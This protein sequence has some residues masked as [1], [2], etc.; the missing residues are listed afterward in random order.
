MRHCTWRRGKWTCWRVGQASKKLP[1][2]LVLCGIISTYS[3]GCKSLVDRT[4]AAHQTNINT[5]LLESVS[6]KFHN[7]EACTYHVY[8]RKLKRHYSCA[9]IA[10]DR[11]HM[12]AERKNRP[13]VFHMYGEH[14]VKA[15]WHLKRMCSITRTCLFTCSQL[16][17]LAGP[18]VLS[19]CVHSSWAK[20]LRAMCYRKQFTLYIWR[21]DNPQ[22]QMDTITWWIQFLKAGSLA[23]GNFFILVKLWIHRT[24]TVFCGA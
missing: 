9:N 3:C 1:L 18:S 14:N 4:T 7:Y 19:T 20:E 13:R 16:H 8:K 21:V 17:R 15:N 2:I 12:A 5:A 11:L 22:E 6:I 23:R 10:K 24:Y